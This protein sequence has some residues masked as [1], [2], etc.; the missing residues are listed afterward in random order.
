MDSNSM[1]F[2]ALFE[3]S[4]VAMAVLR[5]G[6]LVYANPA[7]ARLLGGAAPL[8][9][10]ELL[11]LVPAPCQAAWRAALSQAL[12]GAQAF[13]HPA[14]PLAAAEGNFEVAVDGVPL[15]GQ[16]ALLLCLLPRPDASQ[17]EI[18]ALFHM[19][20]HD[21]GA[22][23][24]AISGFTR[25]VLQDHGPALDEDG[26]GLLNR[27]LAA[28][29][30]M[31]GMIEGVREYA[32]VSRAA[33]QPEALDL[34]DLARAA[35]D[36][37]AAA[38]PAGPA[39]RFEAPASL[40]AWGDPRLLRS[41]VFQLLAN[42]NKFSRRQPEARV[43]FGASQQRGETAYYVR[44]NG[45]GFDMAHAQKLFGLFQRLHRA[46]EFDGL[47]V[48]LALARCV[49]QR[50]GGRIWAESA[51]GAGASFHFTLATKPR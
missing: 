43:E 16:D 28:G 2:Q 33:L 6:R 10:R 39:V 22:P 15:A 8:H 7:C 27:V 30:R 36:K 29:T 42:A 34:A 38:E 46:D 25:L 20:S 23:L 17:A 24:R 45:A 41:V 9:G 48:G 35:W 31:A 32:R 18:D 3:Q 14:L 40:P 47:G 11:E 44:D 26:R 4:P 51:P 21:L 5:G 50:H 19:V 1:D 49:L 37:L 13:S 12:A